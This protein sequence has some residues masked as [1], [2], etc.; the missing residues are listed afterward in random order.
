MKRI[1]YS[2]IM[3]CAIIPLLLYAQSA[4]KMG[5]SANPTV[6][7]EYWGGID[8]NR[9][10]RAL[11]GMDSS[12]RVSLDPDARGAIFGGALTIAG[13]TTIGDASGDTVTVN[14]AAWTFA[15]DTTV[16]LTGGVN[17]LNVDSDTFSIDATNNRIGI[18]TAAPDMEL[19]VN[20]GFGLTQGTQAASANNLDLAETTGNIFEITGTTTINQLNTTGFQ[21]GSVVHLL[22][23][24]VVTIANNVTPTGLTA[25]FLA[26]SAGNITT[27]ANDIWTFV[28][29]TSA[30]IRAWRVT[31]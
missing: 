26:G 8:Q 31:R 20:G 14:G 3:V 24:D 4:I 29:T 22:F 11:L 17:G 21:N 28:L 13:N 27:A 30:S 5:G 9:I 23:P 10:A 19:D 7:T 15:N 16:A 2:I 12:G 6:N 25:R 18:G 1:L